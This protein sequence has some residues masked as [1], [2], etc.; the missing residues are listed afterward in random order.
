[1][2][3][4]PTTD[5][6]PALIVIGTFPSIVVLWAVYTRSKTIATFAQLG[7]LQ[8]RE[9]AQDVLIASQDKAASSELKLQDK[10]SFTLGVLNVCITCYL[11][12]AAPE[13]FYLWHT[14]KAVMLIG[15]RWYTFKQTSQHYL[16][17]DFCYWAN[18]LGLAYLWLWPTSHE[19]FQVFFIVANGPLAWSVLTFSQSL[20]FHSHSHMTSVFIHVSPMLLSHTLRWLPPATADRAHLFDTAAPFAVCAPEPVGCAVSPLTLWWTAMR[21]IYLPWIVLYYVWVFVLLGPRVK[22]RHYQ[23][24]YDRVVSKVCMVVLVDGGWKTGKPRTLTSLQRMVVAAPVLLY[25][26]VRAAGLKSN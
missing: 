24:L 7:G 13:Y 9:A 8:G 19:L 23:T 18:F 16:L 11:M 14:P 26:P 4:L 10:S 15:L 12:G 17:Y 20:V 2:F 22:S 21:R 3:A 25:A 6:N 1:M 5:A